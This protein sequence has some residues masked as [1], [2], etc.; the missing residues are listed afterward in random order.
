MHCFAGMS[1]VSLVYCRLCRFS[2]FDMLVWLVAIVVG[3]VVGCCGVV[4]FSG[5][6]F[7]G[8]SGYCCYYR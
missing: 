6:W 4:Y 3:L 8:L 7:V 5:C 1:V 2:G